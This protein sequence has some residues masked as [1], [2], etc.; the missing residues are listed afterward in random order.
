MQL[1][2]TVAELRDATATFRRAG[3]TIGFVPTMGFLHIGHLTLV[4]QSKA[5][6]DVTVVSIF[7]N[8]LQFG[9]NE[10]L[11]RYP[12]ISPG[13]AH[14][15][16]RRASTFFS[17]QTSPRCIR[18]RCRRSWMCPNWEASWKARCGRGISPVLRP[19]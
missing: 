15:W 8:P 16:K 19:S 12:A 3:K 18:A 1:V 6:N 4:A 7:V 13:T 5:E 2:K 10:D 14:C 17:H 11:A 9:A